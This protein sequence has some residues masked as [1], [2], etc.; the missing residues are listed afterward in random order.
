MIDAPA[1]WLRRCKH[2]LGVKNDG[3]EMTERHVCKA[4]PNGIPYAIASGENKHSKPIFGDHGIQY[5]K[6]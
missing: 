4:F 6:E 5:E 1:C 2:Y 3:D